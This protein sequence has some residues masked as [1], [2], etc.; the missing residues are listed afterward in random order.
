MSL[1]G[2]VCTL[3]TQDRQFYDIEKGFPE[4]PAYMPPK[5]SLDD[6]YIDEIHSHHIIPIPKIMYRRPRK[7][8]FY[9]TNYN[10]SY[11]PYYFI[12]NIYQSLIF[13]LKR[14][15]MSKKGNLVLFV[16]IKMKIIIIKKLEMKILMRL[17]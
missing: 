7:G 13:I 6:I 3:E 1:N 9:L 5:P 15:T 17:N 11:Y 12:F 16:N 4:L 10:W 14:S 2:I 8:K